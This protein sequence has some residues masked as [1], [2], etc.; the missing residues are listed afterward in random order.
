MDRCGSVVPLKHLLDQSPQPLLSGSQG[1]VGLLGED[2]PS[3]LVTL[4]NPPD[5]ALCDTD[6]ISQKPL[7]DGPGGQ[8]PG[9]KI[10]NTLSDLIRVRYRHHGRQ[11]VI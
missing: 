7:L 6:I 3:L 8:V 10:D 4:D 9:V 11:N 1:S 5:A 2:R